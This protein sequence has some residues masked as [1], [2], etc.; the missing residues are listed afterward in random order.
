MRKAES[1]LAQ[2]GQLKSEAVLTLKRLEQEQLVLEEKV[3]GPTT[4]MNTSVVMGGLMN[5]ENER[6]AGQ[7]EDA[8]SAA[9][10]SGGAR[11]ELAS[12]EPHDEEKEKSAGQQEDANS[13]AGNS[14]GARKELASGEPRDIIMDEVNTGHEGH[15]EHE[16]MKLITER[17]R[18][19][20]EVTAAQVSGGLALDGDIPIDGAGDL[21]E[22][23]GK[24]VRKG[25]K[26]KVT[27]SDNKA[28]EDGE[29]LLCRDLYTAHLCVII[30]KPASK[31]SF[32]LR[33]TTR[34]W[35]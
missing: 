33:T 35:N 1:A 22:E 9:G 19:E 25:K 5:K 12:V 21:G 24:P 23:E 32:C 18:V 15:A 10:N 29:Y 4:G 7:Q 2:V 34:R 13:A 26:K 16:S 6:S 11:K 3:I 28:K 14:G 27:Y 31:I 20:L 30:Y 8:N 17:D